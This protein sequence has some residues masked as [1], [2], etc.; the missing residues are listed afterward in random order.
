MDGTLSDYVEQQL[1]RPI[2]Y[3][4]TL[5]SAMSTLWRWCRPSSRVTDPEN[6]IIWLLDNTAYQS[7]LSKALRHRGSWHA[8]V[9][10][11][12]FE[13]NDG[14]DIAKIVT[15]IAD[16]I[17]IDGDFGGNKEIRKTIEKRLRPFIYH[18]V[19]ERVVTLEIPMPNGQ[20]QLHRIGPSGENGISRRTVDIGAHYIEDGTSVKPHLEED[21]A[22]SMNT[23]FSAPEGW[24][25]ISDVDDTIKHTKTYDR[26]GILRTT[27]A[28]EPEPIRGMPYLY[29][30]I[31]RELLPTWF[32]VSASP[33]NLYPY[34]RKF[35]S[36]YYHHGTLI[37]RDYPFRDLSG[38]LESF[39]VSTQEYKVD[40]MEKIHKWFPHR[41]VLC[42]GDSTQK[43]PEAY[44][45]IYRRYPEWVQAIIIRK[46]TNVLN[47]DQRNMP[48]RFEAAFK[49]VPRDVWKVFEHPSELFDRVDE[50]AMRD[51]ASM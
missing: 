45:E 11:C 35:L 41:R 26:L 49:G 4:K 10:A 40:R 28:E 19:S 7:T 25:V 42:V 39:T 12:V 16:L 46:V 8:Q 9:V 15:I 34:L 23:I 51:T 1:A 24:L 47:M 32:Y 20:A 44:A 50:L 43:D 14:I 13:K 18:V 17:G 38:M 5:R 30:Q 31:Q 21:P 27:F 6:D 22:V 36:T 3:S 33:Y 2:R 37:L 29:T 48:A